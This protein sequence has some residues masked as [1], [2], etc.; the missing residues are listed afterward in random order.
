MESGSRPRPSERLADEQLLLE[1]FSEER[2]PAIREELV[3]RFLPLARSLAGRYSGGPEPTED[4]V[5]V[6][7]LGL[8]K[9]IDGFDPSRGHAFAS[10]AAPTILGEL[11][12]HFRDRSRTLHVP[13]GLGERIGLIER[14]VEE[15]PTTLGRSPTAVDV[16]EH[17]GLELEEVLEAMEASSARRTF[18][19]DAPAR[20][21]DDGGGGGQLVDTLGGEDPAYDTVEYGEAIARTLAELPERERTIL[22]LRFV[23]DL[24]QSEIAR[25]VGVSQ[26]HVSRLLRRA[27]EALRSEVAVEET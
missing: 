20:P 25:Q 23:E 15:L 10:Y 17:V 24:T 7:S 4:L 19:L 1:R 14:A 26:M 3:E 21:D 5:Q 11:K 8:V 16:A 9:A 6:A 2:D 22:R 12:R 13:R 18:S 27:I